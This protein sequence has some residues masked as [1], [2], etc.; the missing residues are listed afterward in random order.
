MP[1]GHL[2]EHKYVTM[3]SMRRRISDGTVSAP[4]KRLHNYKYA[5]M[6]SL[7]QYIPQNMPMSGTDTNELFYEMVFTKEQKWRPKQKERGVLP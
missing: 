1:D 6:R 3:C 7:A 5:S 2:A 4:D